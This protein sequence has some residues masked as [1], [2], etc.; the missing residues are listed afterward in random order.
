MTKRR[1][2][3][4]IAMSIIFLFNV[5]AVFAVSEKTSEPEIVSVSHS[6]DISSSIHVDLSQYDGTYLI[7][8]SGM[9]V[10]E[11]ALIGSIN[12]DASKTDIIQLVMNNAQINN[13]DGP[14]INIL[15][16]QKV[17]I[18]LTEDSQNKI[19]CTN[20][21][22]DL[23]N[24]DKTAMYVQS[25]MAISGSGNLEIQS[26]IGHGILCQG[27]LKI[28]D[29]NIS[30]AAFKDGMNVKDNIDIF[31]GNIHIRT[32]ADGIVSTGKKDDQGGIQID[33]GNITIT[34]G[35]DGI[36]AESSLMIT[37]GIFDIFTGNGGTAVHFVGEEVP[38]QAI[39]PDSS[40]FIQRG[41]LMQQTPENS[42][43]SM[44]GLK[45]NTSLTLTGGSFTI[46]SQDD[47]ISSK[48]NIL[49]DGGS[50]TILT[51]D[52]GIQAREHLHIKSGSILIIGCYEGLEGQT[53]T[54]DGGHIDIT[55]SDDGINAASPE[56]KGIEYE[57]D[58][59]VVINGGTLNIVAGHDAIDSNGTLTIN[60]GYV[61]LTIKYSGK[62]D[63]AI[64]TDAGFFFNGGEVITNDGSEKDAK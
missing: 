55:A 26:E 40:A 4:F 38:A 62:R 50:Y 54:I 42:S 59:W 17:S 3:L 24:A 31:N 22:E 53:I 34:A 30:I 63:A 20:V 52:D 64:D 29:G 48:G 5:T 43:K 60:G 28:E 18:I 12:I 46:N 23:K 6:Y 11:G 56:G 7:K 58:V 15:K 32:G 9:Y 10:L 47:A 25:D 8:S 41:S 14:G 61:N 13:P 35:Q 45:A 16:A 2:L 44:K 1:N 33:G 51:S 36:Q 27:S 39:D 21:N 49:I 19:S 37:G 57:E